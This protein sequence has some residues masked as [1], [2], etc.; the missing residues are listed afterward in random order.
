MLLHSSTIGL[1]VITTVALFSLTSDLK[2]SL[3]TDA[4]IILI[5][6]FE[7]DH[8]VSFIYSEKDIVRHWK[9]NPEPL[10]KRKTIYSL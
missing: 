7:H 6:K 3:D 10:P 2:A 8:H 1:I 9:D 5:E 4:H